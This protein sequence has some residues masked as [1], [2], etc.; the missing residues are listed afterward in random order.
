MAETA[1]G[2]PFP[3]LLE[4]DIFVNCIYLSS[5]IPPFLDMSL[6]ERGGRLSVIVDVSCDATNPHNPIPIY[7]RNTT[8]DDPVIHVTAAGQCYDL[9]AIDHL[10]T[11]LPR[12]SSDRF[13][14]DLLPT[15]LELKNFEG[16]RVW[17]EALALFEA[18]KKEA[19]A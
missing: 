4:S 13:S 1:A 6:L 12:E 17:K 9:V 5:P 3:A 7:N 15:F 11:L 19:L 18:K 2:G 14:N 10:P 8:F 16:A